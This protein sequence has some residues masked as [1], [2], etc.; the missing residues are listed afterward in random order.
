LKYDPV[1]V[2][3]QTS[4]DDTVKE[5]VNLSEKGSSG[6]AVLKLDKTAY[7]PDEEMVI[8]FSASS[9]A[10][11]NAWIGIIPSDVPH[12]SN[13]ENDN[14]DIDFDFLAGHISGET[15]LL[16]PHFKGKYHLRM[17]DPDTGK[18]LASVSFTVK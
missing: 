6:D 15:L 2:S 9:D 18:E 11:D 4:A 5:A 13:Q 14:N 8:S 3:K 16:A 7:L 1:S 17:S 12:G 10:A